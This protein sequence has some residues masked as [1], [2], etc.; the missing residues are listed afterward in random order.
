M[1]KEEW[2]EILGY[3]GLYEISSHGRVRS[4]DRPAGIGSGQYARKGKLKILYWDK[5]YGYLKIAAHLADWFLL[6]SYA[7]RRFTRSGKYPICSWLVAHAFSKAG[8]DFRVDPGAAQPDD[9]WDFIQRNPDKYE[10]IHPLQPL[11]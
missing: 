6:G 8:K 2:R 10:E 1:E 4:M 3:E 11:G 5:K 9:I 7:F